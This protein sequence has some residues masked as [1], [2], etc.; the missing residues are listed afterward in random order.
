MADTDTLDALLVACIQDL[1]AGEVLTVARSPHLVEAAGG[2]TRDRM[3][4]NRTRSAAQA[5]KLRG[6]AALIGADAEGPDNIW[7]AG[8][9]DDADRDTRTIAPGPLLDT[10]LIGAIRKGKQAEIVSYETAIAVA[11]ALGHEDVERVLV[12]I[13]AEEQAIDAGFKALLS[14]VVETA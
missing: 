3:D 2:E 7:M 12:E 4:D 9:F 10:A 5:E 6:I 1:Y 11:R 8:V 14:Q 13:H